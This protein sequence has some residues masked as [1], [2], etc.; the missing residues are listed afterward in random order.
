MKNR[1]ILQKQKAKEISFSKLK[2]ILWIIKN[3]SNRR[4]NRKIKFPNRM[5]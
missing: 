2:K 5:R 4:K 1:V 3:C